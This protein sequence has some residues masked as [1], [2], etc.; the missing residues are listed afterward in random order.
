[1]LGVWN[2]DPAS[3]AWIRSLGFRVLVLGLRV[4]GPRPEALLGSRVV[5]G[6][7]S[8]QLK[9]RAQEATAMAPSPGTPVGSERPYGPRRPRDDGAM[10]VDDG[11]DVLRELQGQRSLDVSGPSQPGRRMRC[12]VDG[13]LAGQC[14]RLGGRASLSSGLTLMPTCSECCLDA[15]AP[16]GCGR[17]TWCPAG[18]AP[19]WSALASMGASIVPARLRPLR[20]ARH[21]RCPADADVS[22][23]LDSL[24][25]LD[26]ICAAPIVT[27]EFVGEGLPLLAE[28][29]FPRCVQAVLQHNCED[30]WDD[31]GG[32]SDSPSRRLCRLAWAQLWMFPKTC[33]AALPGGK[34]K[35]RRNHNILANR[36]ERWSLGER[37]TLWD[38]AL[39]AAGKTSQVRRMLTPRPR[40]LL[41]TLPDVACLAKQT[42]ARLAPATPAVE[43]AMRAKFPSAPPR[44]LASVRGPAPS[45]TELTEGDVVRAVQAFPHGSAPGPSGLRAD[46]LQQLV[47]R[48]TDD[49]A[50]CLS[51]QLCQS[52]DRWGGSSGTT[53]VFGWSPWHCSGQDQQTHRSP[54]HTPCLYQ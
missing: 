13:C 12:P 30:A 8:A 47:G 23:V 21:L 28:R 29:E 24:P 38:E 39:Q 7:R 14:G 2:T 46:F 33:L 53:A 3:P 43:A 48:L 44:Q 50:G 25:S 16:T 45:A 31:C 40:L 6:S 27:R 22:A 10:E 37:R 4:V 17:K 15:P 1:M 49:T 9:S 18:F 41:L 52:V 54:G 11:P 36:L 34:A 26:D 35:R 5:S 19:N 42:G 20:S 51:S 32:P